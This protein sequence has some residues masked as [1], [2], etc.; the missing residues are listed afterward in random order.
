MLTNVY[1]VLGQAAERWPTRPA[2]IGSD[3][4]ETIDY[5]SLAQQAERVR[6]ALEAAG[7][8]PGHGVGLIARN[9]PGFVAGAFGVMGAGATVM[10]ISHQLRQA[11]VESLLSDAPVHALLC[12]GS[13]PLRQGMPTTSIDISGGKP[14]G[15]F[16]RQAPRH[17]RFIETLDDIAFMRFT[18]GTTGAAK[19]VAISHRGML[20]RTAAA[21]QGLKLG[22][23]D[24][25]V[26]VLQMA[27]HFVVSIV[28][29]LRYGVTI[30]V[31]AD[32]LA[33]SILEVANR[34]QGTLLYAAPIHYRA[35]TATPETQEFDSLRRAISTSTALPKGLAGAFQDRYGLPITQAYGIIEVGLPLI[36]LQRALDR[37]EAVGHA[38]PAYDVA[39]LDA[40]GKPLPDGASGQLGLK[41]PGMFS[42]YLCP[43]QQRDDVLCNGWFLTGD[44]ARRDPDGVVTIVGR[45]KAMINV[46]GN[47]VFPE[48]VESVLDRHPAVKRSRV[49]GR[50]HPRMGEILHAEVVLKD[51]DAPVDAEDLIRFC[52]K[53]LSTYRVP[54]SVVTVNSIETTA[55]GKI[56][57]G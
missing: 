46:A 24:T 13:G 7:V 35:L 33:E 20:E 51:P 47:K 32:N 29:Y 41:G 30:A 54:H 10:P 2:M 49:I 12:D 37:P 23:E 57:R 22:P 50:P 27:F 18:S 31:V 44:L 52:R 53:R 21:N 36:N 3:G 43:P 4:R 16:W 48:E 39:V 56:R 28:L 45:Q 5:Q 38:L 6:S 17:Q 40:D 19:G 55:S 11:E 9:G 14:L 8:R 25:A 34:H 15:L 1:Q 26:W 42:G